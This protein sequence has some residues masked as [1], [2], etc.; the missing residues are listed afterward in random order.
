MCQL[1]QQEWV[2]RYPGPSNDVAGPFLAVDKQGNSYVAGTHVVNDTINILCVKYNTSGIQLWAT[3][4]KP[5]GCQHPYG[6][7]L[8]TSG[9]VYV[10]AEYGINC[11]SPQN[12]V[13]VKYS[14]IN[15]QI[16]W[17]KR[18]IGL[19]GWSEPNDIKIDRLNN[20]Y[21]V[22][23]SSDSSLLCIK[24]NINGDSVWVRRWHP[25]GDFALGLKCTID[26]SLNVLITGKRSHCVFST[27][28]DS[29]LTLKYTTDGVLRWARTYRYDALTNTGTKIVTD[30][31]GNVYVGGVTRI[32]GYGVY[33][34]LKYDR[35]GNQQWVSFYNPPGNSGLNSIAMDRNNN[36]VFATGYSV[37]NNVGSAATIK[38]NATTGDSIWVRRGFGEVSGSSSARDIKVDTSGNTY[39]TGGM[40]GTTSS[41]V[42][43]LKYS[44]QGNT[45]WLITYNGPYNGG[46]GGYALELRNI[47][48]IYVMGVS[49]SSPQITD[50]IVIKFNQI[51]SIKP[52]SNKLPN[53]YQLQQNFPNPFNTLTKIRFSIP[54]SSFIQLKIYDVLGRVIGNP[55]NEQLQPSEYEFTFDALNFT[56]GV[57][58][59]QLIADN[60]LIETKKC[61][62]A[63]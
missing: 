33:L 23:S 62:I 28:Y 5:E 39:I 25:P 53:H 7:A 19:Y 2:A 24:Y 31:F 47:Y 13:T 3:L 17:A 9:N 18:F 29:L 38:Y 21:V 37:I 52:I 32:S 56:S 44:P 50:Y 46:D 27:C 60:K 16:L 49:F 61:I 45:V 10:T 51:L 41:D 15:G 14:A 30:Q 55:V 4:Y 6:I 54:K 12:I 26:D 42:S 22:G 57:Y 35:N 36:A 1:V 40:P 58:F 43:T 63:K 34:T 11:I 59:Y 8:D 20:I 48:E